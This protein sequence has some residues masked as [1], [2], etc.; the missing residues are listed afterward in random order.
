[1]EIEDFN[2]EKVYVF[3]DVFFV[4]FEIEKYK[5]YVEGFFGI[6]KDLFLVYSGYLFSIID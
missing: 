5:F 6:V 1:M 3:Y 2:G 4:Y